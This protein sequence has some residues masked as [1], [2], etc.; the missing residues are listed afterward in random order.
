[1]GGIIL[2]DK[3]VAVKV[4]LLCEQGHPMTTGAPTQY[5]NY[6]KPNQTVCANSSFFPSKYPV[7]ESVLIYQ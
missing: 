1:M 2:T 4:C 5:H 6:G 7:S 3:P